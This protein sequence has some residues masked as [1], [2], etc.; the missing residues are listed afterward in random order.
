MPKL[1]LARNAENWN[2]DEYIFVLIES[3]NMAVNLH[4]CSIYG[5]ADMEEIKE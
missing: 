2:G 5:I 1:S 4:E 3:R